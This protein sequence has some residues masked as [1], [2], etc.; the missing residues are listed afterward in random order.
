M[1][2]LQTGLSGL[3]AYRALK[4][5][6]QQQAVIEDLKQGKVDIVIGT[7]KTATRGGEVA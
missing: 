6:K 7:H 3:R 2:D 4:L 5:L 1:I